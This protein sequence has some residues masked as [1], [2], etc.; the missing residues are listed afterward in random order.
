M[1]EKIKLQHFKIVYND[2]S[3]TSF[4]KIEEERLGYKEDILQIVWKGYLIDVGWTPDFNVEGHLKVVL[5]K[6]QNWFAPIISKFT[7]ASDDLFDAIN[8]II[9]YVEEI[10]A[11]A[12]ENDPEKEFQ[13]LYND[14]VEH[15]KSIISI[16]EETSLNSLSESIDLSV[17]EVEKLLEE[18]D[19]DGFLDGLDC[20]IDDFE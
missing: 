2:F 7:K 5:I 20:D 14:K 12:K 19:S 11:L 10:D 1:I 17:E 16:Y 15:L 4:D 8:E 6:N 9:N 18:L 13:R 3:I